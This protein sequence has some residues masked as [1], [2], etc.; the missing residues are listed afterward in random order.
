[1]KRII[2][3]L[4]ITALLLTL[5]ACGGSAADT[6]AAHVLD[7]Q[8]PLVPMDQLSPVKNSQKLG[9]QLE[10]P[11]KGEEI[12]VMTMKTGEVIKIRFFPDEAPKAV[13]N[14]KLHAIQGYYDGLT[15]H[16]VMENFM[17]QGG[18]PDGTGTDGV[19]V[20]DQDFEDEFASNLVNID[21]SLSMANRGPTTNGSQF[22]INC[23]NT[24]VQ[25]SLWSQYEQAFEEFQEVYKENKEY[26]DSNPSLKTLDMDKV[27]DDYKKLY[28]AQGGNVHLDGTYSTNGT[29][30]TVFGQVFE[31]MDSVYALSQAET[32]P[33]N[34]KPLED[35][36][37]EKVEIVVY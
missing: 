4:L 10:E 19:S 24:P 27:N 31:G 28:E 21:G 8:D 18:S 35:M 34:D 36:V 17:I 16:R 1:M 26:I 13:Y 30:H 7:N 12:A 2:S 11:A 14:F 29:G 6:K 32:D 3:M 37:I 25:S 9:Y 22:F 20:W 15:F 23:T 33:N 5:A